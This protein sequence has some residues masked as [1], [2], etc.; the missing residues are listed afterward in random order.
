ML[1]N[2]LRSKL[3]YR[4][5]GVLGLGCVIQLRILKPRSFTAQARNLFSLEKINKFPP[6]VDSK[7]VYPFNDLAKTKLISLLFLCLLTEEE[8]LKISIRGMKTY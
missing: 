3:S 6:N 2:S 5:L 1:I 8:R 7:T 4:V